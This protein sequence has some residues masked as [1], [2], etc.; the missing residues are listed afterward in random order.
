MRQVRPVGRRHR[1][2]RCVS[3]LQITPLPVPPVAPENSAEASLFAIVGVI[4]LCL[5][6]LAAA[7]LTFLHRIARPDAA[8]LHARVLAAIA[9]DVDCAHV[10]VV[11]LVGPSVSM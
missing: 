1:R 10:D 6:A 2:G 4:V 9:T 7:G 3:P 11:T 5:V 8:T